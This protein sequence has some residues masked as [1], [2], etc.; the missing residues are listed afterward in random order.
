L[1]ENNAILSLKLRHDRQG[2]NSNRFGYLLGNSGVRK[3][4][5][6]PGVN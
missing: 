1:F 2:E 5:G 6:E 4:M 3:A